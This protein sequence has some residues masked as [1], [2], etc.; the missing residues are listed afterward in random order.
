MNDGERPTNGA[1]TPTDEAPARDSPDEAQ[2][3]AARR[4]RARSNLLVALLCGLLGFALVVQVRQTR[5]DDDLTSLRQDELVQ[6]LDEVTQ[7][8]EDLSRERTELLAERA[9]LLTSEDSR[10]VAEEA[11]RERAL[12]QGV[13]AGTLPVE[14]RGIT[15][16]VVDLDAGVQAHTLYTM[17]QELRNAGAEAIEVSGRRLTATSW[18]ADADEGVVVDGTLLTP[19]YRWTAIGD[20]QTLGVALGIPGGALAAVR[21]DGGEALV[22][23][24]ELVRI[25]AVRSVPEPRF[26]TPVPT[27]DGSG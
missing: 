24:H 5:D 8:S 22:E 3:R 19:P 7:R 23:R 17:L 21:N 12:V 26:A 25:T 16:T 4:R 11:A 2:A 20:P 27:D 15:V 1:T 10:R 14:G 13:L 18:I 6:L 9:E